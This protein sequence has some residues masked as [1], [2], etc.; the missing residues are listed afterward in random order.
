M[1]AA[2]S[3]LS[4]SLPENTVGVLW[5]SGWLVSGNRERRGAPLSTGF[6][7]LASLREESAERGLAWANSLPFA[8]KNERDEDDDH[9]LNV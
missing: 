7:E 3:A 9:D 5:G 8:E 1:S 2:I 4:L 6:L